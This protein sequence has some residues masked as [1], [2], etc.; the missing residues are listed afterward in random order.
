MSTLSWK[1][2]NKTKTN[3]YRFKA[4]FYQL[5]TRLLKL[6]G[7]HFK[8]S[9]S[10]EWMFARKRPGEITCKHEN[11][12]SLAD[13]FFSSD[14]IFWRPSIILTDCTESD[15]LL[16]SLITVITTPVQLVT[17]ALQ[18]GIQCCQLRNFVAKFRNFSDYPSNL[19]SKKHLAT[20]LAMFTIYLAT[21]SN[22]W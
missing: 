19:F 18:R 9:F 4:I 17:S 16:L 13:F 3:V 7:L 21:F 6:S 1:L 14:E 8:I 11:L 20:N 10:D 12:P 22:F 2:L 5:V 15:L